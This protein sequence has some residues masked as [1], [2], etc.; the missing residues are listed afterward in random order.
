MVKRKEYLTI[1]KIE[2]YRSTYKMGGKED[3]EEIDVFCD[4]VHDLLI[5]A[6]RD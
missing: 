1:E 3:R 4:L 5:E 2:Y 6:E